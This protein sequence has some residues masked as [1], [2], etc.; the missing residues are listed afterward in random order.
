MQDSVAQVGQGRIVNRDND[1]L[2]RSDIGVILLRKLWRQE[3]QALAEGLPMREWTRP[4]W[5][6]GTE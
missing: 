4:E 6:L 2:G 5:F 1:H 3:L